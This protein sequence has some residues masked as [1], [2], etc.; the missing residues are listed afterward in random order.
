MMMLMCLRQYKQ[1]LWR[2][3]VNGFSLAGL[4]GREMKDL[5]VGVM[6]TGRIGAQVIRELSG[7]G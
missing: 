7:F 1:A 4:M 5:T 6:G 2:G 3:Q